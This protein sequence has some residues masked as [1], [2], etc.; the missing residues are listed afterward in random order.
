MKKSFQWIITIGLTIFLF[1]INTYIHFTIQLG[2]TGKFLFIDEYWVMFFNPL[3]HIAAHWPLNV[4][5]PLLKSFLMII[6]YI[7]FFFSISVVFLYLI[8]RFQYKK[9]FR[10]CLVFL[11]VL[12]LISFVLFSF[13]TPIRRVGVSKLLTSEGEIIDEA[14]D[15]YISSDYQ[16]GNYGSCLIHK[17]ALKQEDYKE[18]IRICNTLK[19]DYEIAGGNRL[20][21]VYG[22]D[23]CIYKLAI[24][25]KDPIFCEQLNNLDYPDHPSFSKQKCLEWLKEY[26]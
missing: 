8:R 20:V 11:I 14:F 25:K 2:A 22:R 9:I 13:N 7:L 1:I 21:N 4:F 19:H 23:E 18:A 16:K 3:I 17:V 12:Y 26:E 24:Y 10:I 5:F 6:P 15:C